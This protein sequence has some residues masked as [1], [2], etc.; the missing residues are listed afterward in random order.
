MTNSPPQRRDRKEKRPPFAHLHIIDLS[1]WLANRHFIVKNGSWYGEACGF[2]AAWIIFPAH[3]MKPLLLLLF[4]CGGTRLLAQQPAVIADSFS[5][6]ALPFATV[7]AEGRKA[8]LIADIDGRFVLP[9]GSSEQLTVSYVGYRSRVLQLPLQVDTVFLAPSGK[10]MEEVVVRSQQD[11]IRRIVNLAVAA[12]PLYNPDD[13][14]QYDCHIYYKM[15][16]DLQLDGNYNLDS[17]RRQRDS[18]LRKQG[19][20]T[21]DAADSIAQH[22]YDKHLIMS[23]TYSRRSYKRPAKLQETI[24]ASRFSGLK[25]TYFT[26]IVTAVVPFHISADYI[27]LN[28]R[29]F[30]NPV[31]KGW[32][33]R[34]RFYLADEVLVGSDTVFIFS[35]EPRKGVLFNSL[36]GLAYISSRGY[37]VS[38]FVATNSDTASD[39]QVKLEIISGY[40]GDRWFPRE[41]N[42]D[43][44]IRRFMAPYLKLRWNGHSVIDSVNFDASRLPRFDK[45]HTVKLSDSVDLHPASHWEAFRKDSISRKEQNTYRF[46][47][48]LGAKYHFDDVMKSSSRLA[49]GRLPAGNVEIDLARLYANNGYEGTRLG[50]GL[51]TSDRISR[52]LSLGG[53]AGYGFRDA[54]WK[55]GGSLTWYP[56]GRRENKIVAAYEHTYRNPG[57]VKI[58]PDLDQPTLRNWIL[59][60][61]DAYSTLGLTTELHTGYWELRSEWNRTE[62]QPRYIDS[63]AVGGKLQNSF[64]QYEG[65]I[66]LRY[67][68]GE[69]RVP[70]FDSYKAIPGRYPV[71]YL[72]LSGGSVS[73][74]DFR[75]DYARALAAIRYNVHIHRWG[76]DHYQLEG[77]YIHALNEGALPRSFLLAGNGYRLES[78]NYYTTGGFMTMKPFDF[79]NDRYLSLYYRHDFDRY[80]W[81]TK[82][83]KPSLTLAYNGALGSLSEQSRKASPALQSFSQGYHEAGV[84][85]NGLLRINLRFAD[86]NLISGAF[87]R[88]SNG[89]SWSDNGVI[90]LGLKVVL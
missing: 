8:S 46:M 13:Y 50:L 54:G 6:R 20:G 30:L 59:R 19:D 48:S 88:L 28:G 89:G 44:S 5:H 73:G 22:H 81:E 66:G 12:R 14:A 70:V 80:F 79:Y 53:W 72:R 47:D 65:T 51:Y 61:V 38:H 29:D 27:K 4:L 43:F 35:F 87:Y 42:Y 33:Q 69:T 64:T 10:A 60:Q 63:F 90:A 83:S 86:I 2:R 3:S 34:Y 84:L 18:T 74:N 15:V 32:Q 57:E 31:A 26:N 1:H 37:A 36:R 40:S 23:E 75:T 62:L 68:F 41:L 52:H 71:F 25:K 21:E 7:Q 77:G 55:Y 58:H 24:L 39:R 11:K 67:A 82:N 85:L 9:E 76:M 78:V 56:A 16:A 49:E 45:A 17:L